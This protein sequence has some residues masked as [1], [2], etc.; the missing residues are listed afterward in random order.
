MTPA[1]FDAW[2]TEV[3][4]VI[5]KHLPSRDSII[6]RLAFWGGILTFVANHTE[7]VPKDYRPTVLDLSAVIGFIG[8]KYGWSSAK[9]PEPPATIANAPNALP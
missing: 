5:A 3:E 7:L 8:G 4:Q 6:W 2:L 1:Q 9:A